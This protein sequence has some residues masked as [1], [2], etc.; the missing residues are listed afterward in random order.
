MNP[1]TTLKSNRIGL[2]PVARMI[3]AVSLVL[4]AL[5]IS[6]G[7][8]SAAEEVSFVIYSFAIEGNT[9]LERETMIQAVEEFTG[10]GKT[11]E[12]VELARDALEKAYHAEGFPTVLVNIPEQTVDNGVIRLEA[13]ESRIK[14]VL[15]SG[16]KY[17]TM[18]KIKQELPS[19]QPG[20]V[21]YLPKVREDLARLNGKPD[22]KAELILIPGRELGT[23][24][25]ELKVKDSLPLHGSLELNN[26]SSHTTTAL[27][28][29]GSIRYDNLWQKDHSVSA[30][31]QTSPEDTQEVRLFSTSYAMPTPWDKDH[32]LIGYYVNSDSDTA[33]ASGINVIGKGQIVGLRY[34]AL[35]PGLSSYD[36]NL[37]F[38]MDWKDFDEI[39]EG[40][41]VPIE[42]M[43]LTFGYAST[44]SGETGITQF[45]ADINMLLRG[46]LF[47]DMDEFLNKRFGA[48]GN[49]IY[50]T[51]GIERRQKLPKNFSL[52]AKVDGQIADQPLVNNEQF[53]AGGVNSVRGYKEAEILSDNAFHGTLE[54]FGPNLLKQETLVP[55][56]FYDCAWLSLREALPGEMDNKFIQGAGLGVQGSIKNRIEYKLD[57]GMALE[58]TD[59]TDAGDHQFYF[60]VAYRF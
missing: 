28:L 21:L 57:W 31:F 38:G 60:K 2:N 39:T 18:E 30:Q 10:Y 53:S 56:A 32:L 33:S 47:N 46:I 43:P 15:V 22:I 40:E 41:V 29:N 58:D 16:N 42:Y 7:R 25:V 11:A 4:A 44:L 35:L 55:Y 37:T 59:D 8:T 52:F 13:I 50:F 51:G 17:Y 49:Y 54:V 12:D 9:L 20:R 5:L 14:R 6:S 26:R 19:I 1:D 27:R 48:T 3:A 34:M 24:D 45:S 36:H 23:I